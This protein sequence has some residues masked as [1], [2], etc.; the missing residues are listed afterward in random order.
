[1]H[2]FANPLERLLRCSP[3]SSSAVP[4][5]AATRALPGNFCLGRAKQRD[6]LVDL[7]GEQARDAEIVAVLERGLLACFVLECLHDCRDCGRVAL[8]QRIRRSSSNVLMQPQAGA[9]ASKQQSRSRDASIGCAAHD[10]HGLPGTQKSFQPSPAALIACSRAL[11]RAS[12]I[13]VAPPELN[14]TFAPAAFAALQQ[15]DVRRLVSS[16]DHDDDAA[17]IVSERARGSS[18]PGSHAVTAHVTPEV[19]DRR[20]AAA[21]ARDRSAECCRSMPA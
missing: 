21:T 3:L 16:I 4:R 17:R 12:S 13:A 10:A 9:A 15:L 8:R 5:F 2:A 7:A 19:A 6:G 1:M 20:P 18:L 11:S 14:A